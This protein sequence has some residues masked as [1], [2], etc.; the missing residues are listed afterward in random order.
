MIDAQGGY[1]HRWNTWRSISVNREILSATLAVGGMTAVVHIATAARDI[2]LAYQFGTTDVLDAFLIAILLPSVAISIVAGSFASAFIPTYISVQLL[3]GHEAAKRVYQS[4]MIGTLILLTGLVTVLALTA[5]VIVPFLGSGFS[6]EKLAFTRSLLL[7]LLPVLVLKGVA[8]VWTAVLNASERFSVAAGIPILTPA[9]TIALL[10]VMGHLWGI[11]SLVIGT[12]GGAF[13]ETAVLVWHLRRLGIPIIPHWS[14]WSP[15]IAEVT[16]QYGPM[17]AGAFLMSST[18]LVD[19][20]MAAMLG[21]GSVSTL[22]FGSK[23][24]SFLLAVAATGLG[25]A[26]LPHFS[27]MVAQSDWLGVR[28]TLRTYVRLILLTTVP[29]TLLCIYLS[30][31]LVQVIFERGQFTPHDSALVARSLS[32]AAGSAISCSQFAAAS[33]SARSAGLKAGLEYEASTA[34]VAGSRA[35]TA[36]ESSPRPSLAARCRSASMVISRFRGRRSAPK[37][38]AMMSLIVRSRRERNWVE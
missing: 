21:P 8:A 4:L 16:R 28:H 34:P 17:L 24:V 13:V 31:W 15:P 36:P 10:L 33:S 7:M 35:T 27:R 37:I 6:P 26:V 30:E 29:L 23:V 5:P 38:A 32:G 11:Y 14:G 3:E 2:I 20:A 25:T 19:Q 22:N 1:L 18:L 9:M 12:V